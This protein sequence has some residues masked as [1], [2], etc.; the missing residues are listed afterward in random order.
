[1]AD[2]YLAG[3]LMA[4]DGELPRLRVE[5]ALQL[6][7]LERLLAGIGLRRA[8]LRLQSRF[9]RCLVGCL[10]WLSHARTCIY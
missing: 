3:E 8:E 6:E 5:H 1:M 10:C 7:R 2:A 9:H 4:Q